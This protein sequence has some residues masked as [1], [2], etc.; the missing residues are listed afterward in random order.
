MKFGIGESGT[1]E[2]ARKEEEEERERE[3][4]RE[5]E[6]G[7]EGERASLCCVVAQKSKKTQTKLKNVGPG[8]R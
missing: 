5:S 6:E 7:E 3:R 8:L 1:R 4:E 2:E